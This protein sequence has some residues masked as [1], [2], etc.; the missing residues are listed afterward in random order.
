V[1]P[2]VRLPPVG[3]E[4]SPPDM[5]APQV[6]TEP[7]DLSAAKA[8]SFEKTAVTLEERLPAEGGV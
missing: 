8:S 4:E 2:E 6:T 1:T 3:L 5:E 7:F